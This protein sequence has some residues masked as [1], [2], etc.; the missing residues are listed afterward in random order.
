MP[1]TGTGNEEYFDTKI[2]GLCPQDAPGLVRETVCNGSS[3]VVKGVYSILG[4]PKW[5]AHRA[6]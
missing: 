1:G 4:E 3:T 2:K 6:A 5:M